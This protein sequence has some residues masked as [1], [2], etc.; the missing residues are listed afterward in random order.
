M[1]ST[2][3][4]QASWTPTWASPGAPRW[5]WALHWA[6]ATRC[7]AGCTS[8][9]W[10]RPF[11]ARRPMWRMLGNN[12]ARFYEWTISMYVYIYIY[13][14][15]GVST[16]LRF[17]VV[18]KTPLFWVRLI[19]FGVVSCKKGLLYSKQVLAIYTKH[20]QAK[21][22]EGLVLVL[23]DVGSGILTHHSDSGAWLKLLGWTT[24]DPHIKHSPAFYNE[25]RGA[26]ICTLRHLCRIYTEFEHIHSP[27]SCGAS[28]WNSFD[29]W[30]DGRGKKGAF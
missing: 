16:T 4:S 29:G 28:C 25:L 6:R 13:V 1:N 14:I 22:C 30:T 2:C 26:N 7:R 15:P 12:M 8:S 10:G 21:S 18:C 3:F 23:S 19:L 9:R 20:Y 27:W 5:F 24:L 11:G 17:G